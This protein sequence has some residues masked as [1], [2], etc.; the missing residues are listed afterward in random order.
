MAKSIIFNDV[1][2]G[3]KRKISS[4]EALSRLWEH[5]YYFSKVA[6]EICHDLLPQNNDYDEET[7]SEVEALSK[8]VETVAAKLHFLHD[9]NKKRHFRHCPEKLDDTF[10][11]ASQFSVF[12]SQSSTTSHK[13]QGISDALQSTPSENF[14]NNEGDPREYNKKSIL[15]KMD[16]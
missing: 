13:S 9:Q 16:P 12:D 11:S 15:S 5:K 10:E 1:S 14:P 3:R 6:E 7:S 4:I 2:S 8:T